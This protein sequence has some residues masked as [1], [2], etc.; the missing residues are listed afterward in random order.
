MCWCADWETESPSSARQKHVTGSQ[1]E[2]PMREIKH[3]LMI[4]ES[5]GGASIL[6]S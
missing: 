5:L 6:S 4:I 1:R 3:V 2:A